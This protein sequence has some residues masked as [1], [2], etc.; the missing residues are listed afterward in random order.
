MVGRV[1]DELLERWYVLVQVL[2]DDVGV[3]L[4]LGW[5]VGGRRGGCVEVLGVLV[6]LVE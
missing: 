4:C 3:V 5:E 1:D 6:W 2:H